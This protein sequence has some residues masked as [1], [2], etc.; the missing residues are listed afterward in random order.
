MAVGIVCAIPQEF[1]HLEREL[2]AEARES[3]AG[4]TFARGRLEGRE[5]VLVEA[6]IGKVNAALVTTLLIARFGCD[7]VVLSGVAGGLDPNLHIG[8]LVIAER[9]IQHDAGVIEQE[10]LQVYQAGHVPFFNPTEQLGF[11]VPEALLARVRARLQGFTL[12]PL[13]R[14]AGGA[15]RPPALVFGTI[16]TGDQYLH[17]EATRERLFR[18]LG[19]QAVE[20]E[21][22][23]LAQVAEAFGVG[24]LVIRA[25]SDLAGRD[26]RFDFAAFVDQ[27]AQS[28]ARVLHHLLPVL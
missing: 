1:Q 21:G 27:V 23:A 19:G 20:M 17:C 13:P 22:A 11:T 16:L 12:P 18:E 9:A 26:A 4:R 15:D 14:R 25:L 24:W 6:G 5:V 28:S 2:V 3:C 7:P 10:R 8:D